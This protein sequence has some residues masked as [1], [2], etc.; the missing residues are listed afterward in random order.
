[1]SK[2]TDDDSNHMWRLY[3]LRKWVKDKKQTFT[4]YITIAE[5]DEC[6]VCGKTTDNRP[7]ILTATL[8]GSIQLMKTNIG[9]F[10]EAMCGECANILKGALHDSAE[11]QT[12]L[13]HVLKTMMNKKF[14]QLAER[15]VKEGE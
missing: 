6:A 8:E 12:S 15:A 4:N 10:V 14:G 9:K 11:T 7:L 1:M 13:E 2:L 3:N 5:I